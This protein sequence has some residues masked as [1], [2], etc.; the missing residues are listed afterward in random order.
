MPT[1]NANA[2]TTL[3]DVKDELLI[4]DTNSDNYL[5]T[6]INRVSA[7]IETWLGRKLQKA[8]AIV[9]RVPGYGGNRI[10]VSRYPIIDITQVQ[11]INDAQPFDVLDANELQIENQGT[12]HIY[13]EAGFPWTVPR[14][15]GTIARDPAPGHERLSVEVTY[16]AGFVLPNDVGYPG[17][18]PDIPLPEQIQQATVLQVATNFLQRGVNRG[19][20]RERLMSYEVSYGRGNRFKAEGVRDADALRVTIPSPFITEVT[21]LLV[22]FRCIPQG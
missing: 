12:G 20:E 6:Q 21:D 13:R 4:T 3:A 10:Q 1:L 16:D 5:C 14:P 7:A 2:L 15:K 22:P 19:V 17:V 11:L 18:A 8:T 9:E